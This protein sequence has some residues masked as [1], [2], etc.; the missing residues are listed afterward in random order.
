MAPLHVV[1]AA[2]L[3]PRGLLLVSKRSAPQV[4]FLPGGKLEDGESALDCLRREL[5]EELGVGI[6]RAEPFGE[7]RAPAALEDRQLHMRVFLAALDGEPSPA[8]EIASMTW[9]RDGRE[10]ELAPA[11]GDWLIPRLRAA[12]LSPRGP[13]TAD[14]PRGMPAGS[15]W[16]RARRVV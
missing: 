14:A 8:S 9:W 1:A 7:V 10:L 5:R 3:D 6:A 2:V 11:V 13:H 4:Y 16:A 12:G 15:G